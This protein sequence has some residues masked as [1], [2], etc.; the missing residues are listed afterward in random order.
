MGRSFPR[1]VAAVI[2]NAS[3][4][5]TDNRH[6]LLVVNGDGMVTG[7]LSRTRHYYGWFENY[8]TGGRGSRGGR[9]SASLPVHVFKNLNQ[10]KVVNCDREYV[11]GV[12]PI[13][14][15]VRQAEDWT[16]FKRESSCVPPPAEDENRY[17]DRLIVLPN[18]TQAL[19]RVESAAHLDVELSL[20]PVLL[21]TIKKW[22]AQGESI[23]G[24][25][26]EDVVDEVYEVI[27]VNAEVDVVAEEVPEQ[28]APNLTKAQDLLAQA[29]ARMEAAEKRWDEVKS[30]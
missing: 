12:L 10:W 27:D 22:I 6:L 19:D 16:A 26:W 11:N 15:L 8:R 13:E 18:G 9:N 3:A 1:D 17:L 4:V 7:M 2:R 30:A 20:R 5:F 28:P 25:H 14:D 21:Q 24:R 23:M 29:K